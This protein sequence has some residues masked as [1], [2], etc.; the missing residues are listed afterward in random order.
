MKSLLLQEYF[1]TQMRKFSYFILPAL[2]ACILGFQ[3]K[4]KTGSSKKTNVVVNKQ[5]AQNTLKSLTLEEKIAQFFMVA[6]WP[7][8]SEEHQLEIEELVKKYKIG[9]LIYFQGTKEELKNSISRMQK[10]SKVPLMI[11]MDAEWGTAMRVTFEDRLPY[12][13]T[14][15]AANDEKLTEKLGAILAQDC[16]ELGIHLNFAPVADVNS[17]PKNPVI[18]FR[19]FGE[20]PQLVAKHTLAMMKGMEENGVMTSIKHF[21][22]HGNTDKDS[23][24]E[25]PTV[26]QSLA[27]FRAIDFVP[28]KKAIAAHA[29]TVMVGHLNV[30]SLDA[31]GTPSS[32]SKKTIQEYL[33][34][35][36]GFKGLVISDALNMKAVSDKYGKTEVVVK[37]FEA[38]CDILLYPESISESIEALVKKVKQG[39]ISEAEIDARCLKILEAKARFQEKTKAH[40]TFTE[41]EIDWARKETYEKAMCVVKNV[42]NV[43]PI[44]DVQKR[45]AIVRIGT[46]TSSFSSMTG[47]MGDFDEFHFYTPEEAQ[48]R[49]KNKLAKYDIVVT[50]IHASTV[51]SFENYGVSKTIDSWIQCIPSEV[52]S[53]VCLFGN[54]YALGHWTA[55]LKV[56]A[57]VIGYEN[58]AATQDRIAQL[59]F[60]AIGSSAKL[61]TSYSEFLEKGKGIKLDRTDRLKFSQAEELGISAEKL[62]EIDRIVLKGIKAGA[63]PGCQ[64]LVA[65]KGNIIYSKSFGTTMFSNN[66]SIQ[67]SHIYDIASVSKIAGSTAALMKLQSENAFSLNKQLKDYIPEVTGSGQFGDISL[68]D[69][70]AHQAG[71]TAWIPFYKKTMVDGK[72]NPSIYSKVK[73]EGY[74]LQVAS[75]VWIKNSYVDTL[76]K[77][78]IAS[79]LSGDKKYL[80]S[81]LGYYFVKKI[82]EK[83]S[84]QSFDAFLYNSIYKP[85]GLRDIAFNPLKKFPKYR[86]VP[87]ED[88]KAFRGQM[89]HG[90]VHDPGAAML[91]GVGGH[92]GVFSTATDL[93]AV[94]QLFLNKGTYGGMRILDKQ[95]VEEYTK[96]QFPGKNRRGAGFDRPTAPGTSGPTT[97][98][99][100]QQS[101]GH[102]GFTG[103]MTWADPAYGINFVF[104]SNR[105]CPSAENWKIRDMN[106]R[107]EI[108]R[109]IYEAVLEVE[110]K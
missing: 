62:A 102:T 24:Y 53:V 63:F 72:L 64:V 88:D 107:T 33:R 12:A 28:F 52:K 45:I 22:G 61:P 36:L 83:E 47:K 110:G 73:K 71:L 108:Q 66:D 26:S 92:A 20:D 95:V 44:K 101:F 54:P 18:G 40:K 50:S 8:K 56:D 93:A 35:E 80:Y 31:S 69:M 17:N 86:I 19:S 4:G 79:G 32:L 106:I 38:G 41:G 14:I 9:G 49:L 109:I 103:T 75:D 10:A 42:G 6:T 25:L 7:N 3:L 21:P 5:W 82:V 65:V 91:G 46:H 59:I 43:L 100:S 76:Y 16:R 55:A 29:S 27:D 85:L 11:G 39:K 104:L 68:R 89:I 90:Y 70:M 74:E 48:E 99:V 87:T 78:I 34:E 84:K 60:G 96:A 2:V 58:H 97:S 57:L 94:M 98:L 1:N 81:D 77:R 13:Y 67:D 15:G 23:H 37:A 105:V 30:P 51:R